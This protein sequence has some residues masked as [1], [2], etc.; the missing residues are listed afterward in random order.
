MSL[1]TILVI[2]CG[3]IG[4]RHL[5]CFLQTSRAR[6]TACESNP[7]LAA[8]IAETYAVEVLNDWRQSL[9]RRFDGVVICTPAP[10]HVEIATAALDAGSHVLIEKPLSQ[11]LRGIDGLLTA[12]DRSGRTA[13]V[14]YTLH[15][16]PILRAAREFLA[17]QSL[18]PVKQVTV[19][20]GQPFHVF[21]PAYANTYYR[22]RKAGGGAIQDALTHSVNWVESVLGPVD[23]VLCDCAHQVLPNV[24]VEDTVHVSTRHG[25]ALANFSLNQFQAPN[26]TTYQ[27][28]AAGG[29]VKIEVHNARW[30]TYAAGQDKWQWHDVAPLQ[31]DEPFVLQADAFL[32]LMQGG[33]SR[34]C[35]LEAGLST[36]RFNLAAL[37]SADSGRRVLCA[38]IHD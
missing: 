33:P 24:E 20:T 1:T 16:Y 14:A 22:D 32:D 7:A 38:D 10:T 29:S 26:E 28:N 6:V 13:S 34:L 25:A 8:K 17:A 18:G 21:R 23:S 36:L 35:S 3:S 11:S 31:R 2:G 12:R 37:A 4:E 30:G 27:F 19:T 15:L 9:A 5:R